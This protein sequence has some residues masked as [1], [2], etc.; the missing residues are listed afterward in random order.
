M[1]NTCSKEIQNS[2]NLSSSQGDQESEVNVAHDANLEALAIL[3]YLKILVDQ[4]E[5]HRFSIMTSIIE[6]HRYFLM[7][8]P[9]RM[10]AKG[11]K[12]KTSFITNKETY[13]Y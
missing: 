6:F 11:D 3:G 10:M 4:K 7:L 12:T 9:E 2:Q 8:Q 1:M 5:T 13:Y